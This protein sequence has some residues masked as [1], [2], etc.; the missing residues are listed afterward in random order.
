MNE[1]MLTLADYAEQVAGKSHRTVQR[2]LEKDELPGATQDDDG[3]WWV[4]ATAKRQRVPSYDVVA[5]SS[6]TTTYDV[7]APVAPDLGHGGPLEE[8]ADAIGFSRGGVRRLYRDMQAHPGLP[9]YVG[10]Y[11]STTALKVYAPPR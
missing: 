11:G 3:R 10:R 8:F 2:W 1:T 4:P 5:A 9:F 6:R 7:A